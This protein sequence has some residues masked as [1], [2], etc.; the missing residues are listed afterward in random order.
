MLIIVFIKKAMVSAP[1]K[2]KPK[3]RRNVKDRKKKK[4][5]QNLPKSSTIATRLRAEDFARPH[6]LKGMMMEK[7]GL[8]AVSWIKETNSLI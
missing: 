6:L 3:L 5:R 2:I 7:S 1:R 4:K 8:R